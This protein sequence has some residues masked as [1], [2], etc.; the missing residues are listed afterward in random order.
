MATDWRDR[1]FW[2]PNGHGAVHC[3]FSGTLSHIPNQQTKCVII[4][5]VVYDEIA[6]TTFS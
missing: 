4:Q 1:L 5:V 3:I 6:K 2:Q